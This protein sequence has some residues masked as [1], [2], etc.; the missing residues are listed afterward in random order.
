MRAH[1]YEQLLAALG[2]LRLSESTPCRIPELELQARIFSGEFG[3]SWQGE[4]GESVKIVHFGIWN[5]EPGPDFCDAQVIIDGVKTIGDIEI[6]QDVRDWENH[7]HSRN[8]SYEN[9]ILHLFVRRGQR[10]CFTST[11]GNKA[12]TQVY[13]APRKTSKHAELAREGAINEAQAEKLIEAAA[14]FRLHRKCEIFQR[15]TTLRGCEEALFEAIAAAMGFKNNKI[16]FLLAAQRTSLARA[17]AAHGEALLFGLSGF[18]KADHFDQGETEARAYLRD[19]WE[20][21]WAIRDRERRLILPDDAWIFSAVR[22]A[23]HPHRRMGAL[24]AAVRLFAPISRAVETGNSDAFAAGFSSLHHSFWQRHAS[25]A[26]DPLPKA[27]AL[28]GGDRTLDLLINVFLPAQRYDDAWP[29]LC[30]L[31]GPTP[32]RKVVRASE[33]LVGSAPLTSFRSAMRQ[34]GLLQLA[35]DFRHVS[36]KEVWQNFARGWTPSEI[37]RNIDS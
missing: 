37:V 5:R 34:Q 10:R 27:T 25:L 13:L 19:L 6:D 31:P 9:V 32:S 36:P 17:R 8:A 7:G 18:L 21:W 2:A 4:D 33:R 12:V 22:P 16:P 15:A 24:A 14:A 20:T 23:N 28:I 29:K 30:A 26:G 3:V 11:A 35:E 1:A